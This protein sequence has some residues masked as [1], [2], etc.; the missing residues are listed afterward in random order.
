[1]KV[2]LVGEG[3][4]ELGAWARAPSYRDTYGPGVLEVLLRKVR[5]DG[6]EIGGATLWKDIRKFRSG[7][8]A[9][10]EQRNVLGAALKASESG[11]QLLA[12]VRDRDG[13]GTREAQ[14]LAGI[15]QARAQ[16]P[17]LHLVAGLAIERLEAWMLALDGASRAEDHRHPERALAQRGHGVKDTERWVS[18]IEAADLSR[19][20]PDARSMQAWLEQARAALA[21]AAE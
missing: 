3:P 16:F 12:L 10:A 7:G 6:W 15:E 18:L 14:V 11:C 5:A 9:G 8:S 2:F 17:T 13:D 21:G 4:N 1:M 20:P 19:L